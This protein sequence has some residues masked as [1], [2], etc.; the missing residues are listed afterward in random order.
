MQC[1]SSKQAQAK[2]SATHHSQSLAVGLDVGHEGGE[3]LETLDFHLIR[4]EAL[5]TL[6]VDHITS[7]EVGVGGDG[8]IIVVG[9]G[10]GDAPS[11][12]SHLL[13]QRVER[14]VGQSLSHAHEGVVLLE[15][16]RRSEDLKG[17]HEPV[18]GMHGGS[19]SPSLPC[20]RGER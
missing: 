12:G 11:G 15:E 2:P 20:Q 16:L 5:T 1:V 6:G 14:A 8:A 3:E 10:D 13:E 7:P 9:G 18:R 17:T 19:F 4:F